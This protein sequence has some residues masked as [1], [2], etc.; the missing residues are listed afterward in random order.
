MGVMNDH[1]GT[2]QEL[3]KEISVLKHRIQELEKSESEYKEKRKEFSLVPKGGGK[4][5]R[6]IGIS[7]SEGRHYYQNK[8]VTN[9]FGLSVDEVKDEEGEVIGIVSIQTDITEHLQLNEKLHNRDEWHHWQG[10]DH[11]ARGNT[12]QESL[13]HYGYEPGY[14]L[15]RGVQSLAELV[16][17]AERLK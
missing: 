3:L 12:G 2:N 9:L 17:P 16:R 10:A 4:R 5:Y 6:C 1:A 13:C 11:T 8:A 15:C 7:M 14:S